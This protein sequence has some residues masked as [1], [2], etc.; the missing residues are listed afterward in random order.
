MEGSVDDQGRT[1]AGFKPFMK[2]FYVMKKNAKKKPKCALTTNKFFNEIF[3][4][5]RS[6]HNGKTL[7]TPKYEYFWN[8]KIVPGRAL[9][10]L[11]PHGASCYP[12]Y[13]SF[14]FCYFTSISILERQ[15]TY[16]NMKYFVVTIEQIKWS[17]QKEWN[18]DTFLK[19]RI[20]YVSF[21]FGKTPIWKICELI[22]FQKTVV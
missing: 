11:F 19:W 12:L 9:R 20:I 1:K 5:Y 6:I 17:S 10:W 2:H 15:H 8:A 14:N 18:N 22:A 7:C 3:L 13:I 4:I 21:H 16:E